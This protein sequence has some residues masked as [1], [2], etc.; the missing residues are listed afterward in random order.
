MFFLQLDA[1][2]LILGTRVTSHTYT[3]TRALGLTVVL[4]CLDAVGWTM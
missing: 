1:T 3:H 4:R 2:S